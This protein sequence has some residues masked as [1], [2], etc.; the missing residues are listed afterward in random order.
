MCDNY[1]IVLSVS[2]SLCVS[3]GIGMLFDGLNIRVI[4]SHILVGLF[5]ASDIS[6][7]LNVRDILLVFSSCNILL[8]RYSLVSL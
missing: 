6:L 3:R 7:V 1:L 5:Y 2:P 8:P 4:S